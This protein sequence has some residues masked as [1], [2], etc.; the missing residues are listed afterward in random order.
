MNG[1]KKPSSWLGSLQAIIGLYRTLYREDK[2]PK[3]GS[4]YR[5]M[6]ILE[7]KVRKGVK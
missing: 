2:I 6:K 5:R 7:E 1:I 4:A 3:Y